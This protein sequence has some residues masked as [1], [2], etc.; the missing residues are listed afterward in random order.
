MVFGRREEDTN[1]KDMYNVWN[2]YR[3]DGKFYYEGMSESARKENLRPLEQEEI[4]LFF[5]ML[6]ANIDNITF[7]KRN[8]KYIAQLYFWIYDG[9][10]SVI[11]GYGK[12]KAKAK[13]AL[14]NR[15]KE[16]NIIIENSYVEE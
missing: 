6:I 10:Y 7:S 9:I 3:K 15:I 5:A 4:D 11:Y 16:Y 8:G 12:T 13:K 2:V 1:Y 14:L